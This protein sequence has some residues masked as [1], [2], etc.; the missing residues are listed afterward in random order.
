MNL[1]TGILILAVMQNMSFV[2]KGHLLLRVIIL[3]IGM[4]L[5]TT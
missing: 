3:V 5:V 1:V 2:T 4:A